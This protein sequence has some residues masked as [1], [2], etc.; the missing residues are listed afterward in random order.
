LFY[1]LM[2]RSSAEYSPSLRGLLS[3]KG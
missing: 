2:S 3:D 1:S